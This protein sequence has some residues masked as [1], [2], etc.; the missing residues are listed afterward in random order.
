MTILASIVD[1]RGQEARHVASLWWVMFALAAGVYI[2]VAAFILVALVRGRRTET[3]KSSR[4][5]DDT[6]IWFGGIGVPVVILGVLAGLTV[7]TT[8]AVRNPD[9]GALRVEVVGKRWW[10][11]VDYPDQRVSSANEIHVPVGQQ[12]D[13]TL[14]TDN[15]AHSFWVPQL[16]GKLDLLPGVTN[17]LPIKATKPGVYEGVCAEYCGIQH[18]HMS[19]RVIAESPGD[20][21]RWMTRRAANAGTTGQSELAAKGQLV[22]TREAC[23]GCHTVNGTQATGT[24]GPD[25]SD[26]GGRQTIGAG[27]VPNT[28]GYLA[29]W[30]TNSQTIKSGNLMPPI[31]LSSA[32]LNALVAYLEGL[33]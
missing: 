10:W 30:I 3:G 32:D 11:A 20:F 31:S 6:F 4:I 8:K 28:P 2:I 19:F 5:G 33:K 9:S 21:E 1:W 29:A 23:A 25:L 7:T 16:A 15:V 14:K 27:T 22:F 12:V 13:I 26:F 24:L 18:A 17:L